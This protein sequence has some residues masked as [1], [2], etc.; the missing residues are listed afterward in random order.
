M[1][2]SDPTL[3]EAGRRFKHAMICHGKGSYKEAYQQYLAT[4]NYITSE[5]CKYP[6]KPSSWILFP[7]A[8]SK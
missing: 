8:Y 3:N 7:F 5:L 4:A 2:M 1:T 6:F